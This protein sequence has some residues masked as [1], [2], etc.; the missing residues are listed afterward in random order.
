MSWQH[1]ALYAQAA[2]QDL[3]EAAE[4]LNQQ[5]GQMLLLLFALIGDTESHIPQEAVEKA[6]QNVLTKAIHAQTDEKGHLHVKLVD[7]PRIELPQKD[8]HPPGIVQ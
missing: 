6:R 7:K 8:I 2:N 3:K 4:R 1:K 5:N